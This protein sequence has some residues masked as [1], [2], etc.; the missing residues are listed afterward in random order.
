MGRLLDKLTTIHP[1]KL[2][3]EWKNEDQVNVRNKDRNSISRETPP[4]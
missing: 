4:A 3:I 2:L 1:I